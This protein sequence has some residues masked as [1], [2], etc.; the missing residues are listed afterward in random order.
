MTIEADHWPEGLRLRH[1]LEPGDLGR[2]IALHGEVYRQWPGFG[3][4]F[5]AF[6]ART[7]AEYGLENDFNGRIW[8]LERNRDRQP[9][10]VGCCA[11]AFRSAHLAQLRWVL[12]REEYSGKGL[13]QRMVEIALAHCRQSGVGKVFLETTDGLEASSRLYRKL[14]FRETSNRV[15]PLW[16]GPRPLIRM[17]L[18]L[19][20]QG[21]P[22]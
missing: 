20:G 8:L 17:D 5:E 12:L 4:E 6:V 21:I 10:L 1:E 3:P 22:D 14:G 2:L 18:E 11:I 13:G 7:V 19:E 15:V 9:E 16:S